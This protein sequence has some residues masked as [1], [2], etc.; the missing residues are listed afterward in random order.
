MSSALV[1]CAFVMLHGV[2]SWKLVIRD[3]AIAKG[4]QRLDWQLS[5]SEGSKTSP[6]K[7]LFTAG[8]KF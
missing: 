1:S 2:V 4:T 8:V 7:I 6:E 3:R 5:K